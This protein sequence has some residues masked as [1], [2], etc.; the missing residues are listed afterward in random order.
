MSDCAES[1]PLV[2]YAE[3]VAVHGLAETCPVQLR[4]D[5]G[6]HFALAAEDARRFD[7]RLQPLVPRE[8]AD[9]I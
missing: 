7:E 5:D 8:R 1:G 2:G 4:R 9:V 6:R 3:K